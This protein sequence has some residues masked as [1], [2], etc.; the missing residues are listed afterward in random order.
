ML[1]WLIMKNIVAQCQAGKQSDKGQPAVATGLLPIRGLHGSSRKDTQT[2]ATKVALSHT[3]DIVAQGCREA[4]LLRL[5][6]H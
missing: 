1:A 5:L 2:L 4:V 6:I 3:M